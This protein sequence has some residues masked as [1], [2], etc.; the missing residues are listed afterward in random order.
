MPSHRAP[1]FD[2][3]NLPTCLPLVTAIGHRMAYD[4]AV[5]AGVDPALVALYEVSCM[6]ADAAWYV[7]NAGITRVE[8]REMEARA[9]ETIFPRLEEFLDALDVEPYITAP[10]INEEK[11]TRYVE[12]LQTFTSPGS[13][14]YQGVPGSGGVF[15]SKL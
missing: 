8:I 15:V 9:V 11:W 2:T 3:Q 1:A 10:I 6:K 13:S 12:E 5:A 7:E 4:A 14:V